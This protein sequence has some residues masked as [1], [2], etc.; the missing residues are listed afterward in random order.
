[1]CT[2][3]RATLYAHII[4]EWDILMFTSQYVISFYSLY[5]RRLLSVFYQKFSLKMSVFMPNPQLP[6][7]Q[8]LFLPVYPQISVVGRTVLSHKFF[9]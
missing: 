6:L 5:N 1:M 9:V 3:F 4:P 7:Q 8:F 2:D